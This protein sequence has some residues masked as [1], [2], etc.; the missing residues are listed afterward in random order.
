MTLP[1]SRTALREGR[2]GR[3]RILLVED[4]AA[5]RRSLQM[6]LEGEGYDVRAFATAA[7]LLA[8]AGA[9]GADCLVSDYRIG[10]QDGI[11]L[12][13]TLRQG[14]WPGPAILMSAFATPAMRDRATHE[15]FAQVFD[16]PF[17]PHL[18]VDLVTSLISRA[19]QN[20][21]G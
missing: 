10:E 14:G 8:D 12:L 1:A 2:S 15:G 11:S 5:V 6:L 16:K 17:R 20:P 21:Q 9:L 13:R 18:L 3:P 19:A 7:A 4:D